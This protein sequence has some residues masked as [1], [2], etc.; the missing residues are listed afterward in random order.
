MTT[1]TMLILL[2]FMVAGWVQGVL[3]FGFAVAS[4]LLLVNHINFM[5]LVFLNLCMSLL[6]CVI[7]M[8]SAK[9]LKSIHKPTL[10]KL[11]IS[12]LAGLSL[13]ITIISYVDGVILK[14]V[15]LVVILIASLVSLSKR[16]V[17]FARKY[18]SWVG[19]FLSGALTPST[20]ING[21]LVV[22][23][24]NAAFKDKQQIRTTMLSYLL[25]IMTFGILSM[26]LQNRL[27]AE[28]WHILPKVI[29]PSIVGYALGT[30]TFRWL[31][32]SIFKKTVSLFLIGSSFLSLIY[33]II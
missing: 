1:V 14:Q 33:L 11:V 18:M 32:Y 20:G 30:L 13:G 7:A 15:T 17:F 22:L 21:P 19:G 6:T 23:H 25:V 10:F 24:L 2:A 5:M 4:T 16:K 26:S 28:T 12:A 9:N 3:G 31:S 27:S 8:F 29:L